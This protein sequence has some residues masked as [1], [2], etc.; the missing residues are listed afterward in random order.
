MTKTVFPLR[1]ESQLKEA[2][3][4]RAK[5]ENRSQNELIKSVM[6]LYVCN[7]LVEN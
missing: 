1:L 7:R 6:R 4:D 2:I 3:R 5:L